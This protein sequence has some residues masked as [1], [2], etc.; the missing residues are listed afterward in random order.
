[1]KGQSLPKKPLAR[2]GGFGKVNKGIGVDFASSAAP[3]A[4]LEIDQASLPTG[5]NHEA[6]W[7]G[8]GE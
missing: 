6:A 5:D 7:S 1:M 2:E 8:E 3:A 4:M